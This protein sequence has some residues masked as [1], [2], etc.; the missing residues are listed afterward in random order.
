MRFAQAIAP[1]AVLILLATTASPANARPRSPANQAIL[2][3]GLIA[4]DDVPVGWTASKQS[5]N[6]L[7][8]YRAVPDCKRFVAAA[9]AIRNGAARKLSPTF[10]DDTSRDRLTMAQDTVFAFESSA[11]AAQAFQAL[12]SA[13]A[14]NCLAKVSVRAL[15]GHSMSSVIN[16]SSEVQ[17]VGDDSFAYEIAVQASDQSGPVTAV[18][19]I[20]GLR[21][22]RA[23]VNLDFGNQDLALPQGSAIVNTVANRLASA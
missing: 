22:G 7:K 9:Q 19:D 21:V 20:V 6:A 11:A 14:G 2:S 12:K 15:P 8:A 23:I 3:A 13:P 5:D 16:I 4:R 10:T 1:V 17:G 18:F